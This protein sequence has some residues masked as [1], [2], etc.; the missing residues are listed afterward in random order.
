[1]RPIKFSMREGCHWH[2]S[3]ILRVEKEFGDKAAENKIIEFLDLE[4]NEDYYDFLVDFLV[5]VFEQECAAR[6]AV[7]QYICAKY[8]IC[9]TEAPAYMHY[10]PNMMYDSYT[11]LLNDENERP[12]LSDEVKNKLAEYEKLT[13]E[14]TDNPIGLLTEQ[15]TEKD[16]QIAVLMELLQKQ[17]DNQQ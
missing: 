14:K 5:S 10:M 15:I 13:A 7:F 9:Y 8:R 12:Y 11:G 3:E 6:M 2:L 16:K 4:G 17:K 1:M